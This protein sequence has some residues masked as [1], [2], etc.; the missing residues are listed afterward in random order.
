MS[1]RDKKL[2]VLRAKIT[3]AI[4]LMRCQWAREYGG[5]K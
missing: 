2:A 5:R 3:T 1:E 4:Y